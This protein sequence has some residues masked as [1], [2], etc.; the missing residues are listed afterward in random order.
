ME[1]S[2]EAC[3]TFTAKLVGNVYELQGSSVTSGGVQ[4]SSASKSEVVKQSSCVSGSVRVDPEGKR[5]GRCGH[6]ASDSPAQRSE[7]GAMS[8]GSRLDKG[9]RWVIKFR[10]GLNLFDLTKL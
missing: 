1:V 9:D 8:H 2:K 7:V 3:A 4:I 5:L 10:S 6:D